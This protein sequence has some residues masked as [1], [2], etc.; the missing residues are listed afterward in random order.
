MKY[1]LAETVL[2]CY[3]VL[4][5]YPKLC[6]LR[7]CRRIRRIGGFRLGIWRRWRGGETARARAFG[8]GTGL[9][10]LGSTAGSVEGAAVGDGGRKDV[11]GYNKGH[12]ANLQP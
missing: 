7:V 10:R 4:I 12:R 8:I 2:K 1:L 6:L 5:R 3:S 9:W 11:I